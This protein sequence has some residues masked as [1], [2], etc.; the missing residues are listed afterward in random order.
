MR[1]TF[2]FLFGA[3]PMCFLCDTFK[4]I[5]RFFSFYQST[6]I[7]AAFFKWLCFLNTISRIV[8]S[9][10]E[11]IKSTNIFNLQ[12]KSSEDRFFALFLYS[13]VIGTGPGS[14]FSYTLIIYSFRTLLFSS[15]LQT[16]TCHSSPS[17][18]PLVL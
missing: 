15:Q 10:V 7:F 5:I 3:L 18:F 16:M 11:I 14:E 13:L 1:G 9:D 4:R 12:K 8:F 2:I 17:F 6:F